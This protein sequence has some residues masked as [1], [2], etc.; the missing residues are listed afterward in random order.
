MLDTNVN[1]IGVDCKEIGRSEKAGFNIR[2]NRFKRHH[3]DSQRLK[4][5]LYS[6][7][8]GIVPID[9]ISSCL[10]RTH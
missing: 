7:G 4:Y 3:S 10:I 6:N 1:Q 2:P 5:S 8:C 9:L